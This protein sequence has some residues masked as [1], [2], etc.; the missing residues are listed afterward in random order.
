[1]NDLL[2]R[3]KEKE[4]A[5]SKPRCHWMTHGSKAEVATRLTKLLSPWGKVT[6]E[7][8]W[9][10]DGFDNPTEAEFHKVTFLDEPCRNR[11]TQW[12][13]AV[14]NVKAKTPNL[15]LAGTCRVQGKVG[16]FM[17]EAKAHDAELRKEEAG[18]RLK[19]PVSH[20]S[21][22]NHIRIGACINEASVGL[23]GETRLPWALSADWN[24]QMSNRFAWTWKLC[25]LGFPVIL[26]YLGFLNASEMQKGKQKAFESHDEWDR[27][28]R[29]HSRIL[30]PQ[31]VWN[32]ERPLGR[33][34]V[35]VIRTVQIPYDQPIEE[36]VVT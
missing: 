34:L 16:I 35:P 30:F 32:P 19:P 36:F 17:V 18:K 22:R 25:E 31:Q 14:N 4:R 27:L 28:V 33:G 24:Y 8:H 9:L 12:W 29:E 5:G 21:R 20:G 13:L 26:V 6:P 10:P 2:L 3:L 15:D 7:D 11:L 1:M 23:S